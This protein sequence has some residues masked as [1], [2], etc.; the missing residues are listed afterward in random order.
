MSTAVPA[1]RRP[2][3]CS[4]RSSLERSALRLEVGSSRMSTPGPSVTI[5]PSPTHAE[6]WLTIG[7]APYPALRW[8]TRR[9]GLGRMLPLP[10][11]VGIEDLLA[12]RD[13]AHRTL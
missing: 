6:A 13:V 3:T 7:A 4:S 11:E 1:C 9:C 10:D 2:R 5:R 12:G 8:S